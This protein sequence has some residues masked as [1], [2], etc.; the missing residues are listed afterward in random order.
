MRMNIMIPNI[1][2]QMGNLY[3]VNNLHFSNI[4]LLNLLGI[5]VSLPIIQH[6]TMS[7][8]CVSLK[9]FYYVLLRLWRYSHVRR[10]P[11]KTEIVSTIFLTNNELLTQQ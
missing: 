8:L 5:S 9:C 10:Y 3:S 2:I 7:T 11:M 4:M 6:E 1:K